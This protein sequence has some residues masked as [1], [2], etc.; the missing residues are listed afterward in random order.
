MFT[1]FSSY[2]LGPRLL[3]GA[4]W[5]QWYVAAGSCSHQGSQETECSGKIQGVLVIT[6]SEL[7]MLARFHLLKSLELLKIVLLGEAGT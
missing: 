2:V 7:T 3:S 5:Q 4:S 6:Y 1:G